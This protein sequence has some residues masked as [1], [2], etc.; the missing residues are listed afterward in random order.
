M[1]W[2]IFVPCTPF[3]EMERRCAVS[4]VHA[5]LTDIINT[6][7]SLRPT[8]E[9]RESRSDT[10]IVCKKHFGLKY[11]AGEKLELKTLVQANDLGV[12][13]YVKVKFG[14]KGIKKYEDEIVEELRRHGHMNDMLHR[15]LIH[16]EQTC[17]VAKSRTNV[18][19][20]TVCLEIADIELVVPCN[21]PK[22]WCSIA[23]E[24]SSAM[25]IQSFVASNMLLRRLLAGIQ[26]Y[27]NLAAAHPE[28]ALILPVLGGYPLF[29]EYVSNECDQ[30]LAR[31]SFGKIFSKLL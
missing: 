30:T 9:P 14:K 2:R 20:G 7:Y 10:Y 18:P 23:L 5:T 4:E 13:E 11:R 22:H 25:E 12:E 31:E 3:S 16:A 8:G 28:H 29:V 26:S 24:A 21:A 6:L 17:E 27:L 15:A 1:E 19:I